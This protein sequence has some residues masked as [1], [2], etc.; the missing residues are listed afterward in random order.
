[1]QDEKTVILQI[2]DSL[3][4]RAAALRIDP[5]DALL[6]L[7]LLLDQYLL[8]APIDRL[9]QEGG[10]TK[11]SADAL[12]SLQDLVYACSDSGQLMGMFAGINFQQMDYSIDLGQ[13]PQLET[14][15]AGE[16][17]VPV[18][19]LTIE[20]TN[21]GY[22]RNWRGFHKRK[23]RRHTDAYSSFVQTALESECGQANAAAILQLD[24]KD[25]KLMFLKVV[26]RKIWESDFES[27][28]R[29]IGD[30]LIYKTGDETLRNIIDGAGG[31][32]SEKVQALKFLTDNFGLDSEYVLA[33]DNARAPIPVT[34]LRE[35]L[36]TFDFRFSKRYMRYWQHLALVYDIDGTPVLVDAT[37]GNIP[38][39]FLQG[40][41]AERLLSHQ[42]E[43]FIEVRMVEFLENF[44]YHRVPQD[45]PEN[46]LFAL[47][48]WI[49]D[50]DMVQ[51]FD[52]ELWLYVSKDFYLTP[53]PFK[54]ER[55]FSKLSQEYLQICRR[56]DLECSASRDW[57]LDSPLGQRF[58]EQE[59]RVS[60]KIM[61]GHEH[62]LHR[63]N[64]W[65]GPG[66]QAGLVVIKL[67]DHADFTSQV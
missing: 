57:S 47:E 54:N 16:T 51:I 20:R 31:I 50:A 40:N 39:L 37:N 41:A 3:T 11:R 29:F 46:L 34:R 67:R 56:A 22:D 61:R 63:Y 18:I 21:V 43:T 9:I 24:S 8:H 42:P 7:G 6:P 53:I 26:A 14:A 33:G 1:M 35:L 62:L 60:E 36:T 15:R 12:F 30:K 64:E 49:P 48:G 10:I 58:V 27:Y 38:F 28:S 2:N 23:W 59:P 13:V 65:A 66:H 45:V 55:E 5:Q 44:Y 25:H 52:N 4:A 17:E 32:C 19:D